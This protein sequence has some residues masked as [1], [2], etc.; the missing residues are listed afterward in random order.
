MNTTFSIR[1]DSKIKKSFLASSK[2]KGLDWSSLIRYFMDQF[3]KNPDIVKFEIDENI[4]DEALKNPKI[5]KKLEKISGKL[6]NLW[7]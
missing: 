3:S 5:N 4:F 1:V 7:F 2:A 6:D